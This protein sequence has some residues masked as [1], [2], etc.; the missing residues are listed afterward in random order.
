MDFLILNAICIGGDRIEGLSR[1]LK[2]LFILY[3]QAKARII[4]S[5]SCYSFI[6]YGISIYT[7]LSN[8]GGLDV[9]C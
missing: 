2:I 4:S 5:A 3:C 9:S 1:L 7:A 6:G 8:R